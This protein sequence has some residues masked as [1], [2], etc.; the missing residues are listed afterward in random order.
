MKLNFYQILSANMLTVND[1][2]GSLRHAF[3]IACFYNKSPSINTTI[4]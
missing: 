1:C 3:N 2:V 4:S